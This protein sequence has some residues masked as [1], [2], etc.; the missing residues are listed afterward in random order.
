MNASETISQIPLH[1]AHSKSDKFRPSW[2]TTRGSP[3]S[4]FGMDTKFPAASSI[5]FPASRL[6]AHALL[7]GGSRTKNRIFNRFS[8]LHLEQHPGRRAALPSKFPRYSSFMSRTLTRN[9]NGLRAAVRYTTEG[10][11]ARGGAIR[12]A[13]FRNDEP[14]SRNSLMLG[15]P[16]RHSDNDSPAIFFWLNRNITERRA[17]PCIHLLII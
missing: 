5:Y 10:K 15:Q 11:W 3:S 6:K 14:L 7:S 16:V 8:L 2:S 1:W 9:M 12:R 13:R 4:N 17:T